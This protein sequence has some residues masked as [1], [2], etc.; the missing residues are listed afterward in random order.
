MSYSRLSGGVYLVEVDPPGYTS[1]IAITLYHI[2]AEMSRQVAS[3]M[4]F[5]GRSRSIARKLTFKPITN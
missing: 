1:T 4:S 5:Y 3:P 2:S